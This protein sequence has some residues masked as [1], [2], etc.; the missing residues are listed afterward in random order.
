MVKRSDTGRST[1]I[2]ARILELQAER[3]AIPERVSRMVASVLAREAGVDYRNV[4]DRDLAILSARLSG[5][6]TVAID[7]EIDAQI[8]A[9]KRPPRG[10][11][12]K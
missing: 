1:E 10:A 5:N 4:D 8:A 7:E 11:A 9:L 2:D 3:A 6:Y 12:R